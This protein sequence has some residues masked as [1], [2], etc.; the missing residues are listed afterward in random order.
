MFVRAL[1]EGTQ[2]NLATIARTPL[3]TRFYLAGGTAVALH[4]GHRLSYDLD[5]FSLQPFPPDLP[6]RALAPLGELSVTQESE[7]TFLGAFNGLQI[8][9]FIYPYS[10]LED[11]VVW[12]G[13][14]I[15][16][17]PDIATMKLDAISSRGKKRDFVDLYII[18]QRAFPLSQAIAF[19][20]Q[21]YA[22]VRYNKF[23]LLK[24]LVYFEDAEGDEPPQMLEACD[25]SAVKG[26]FEDK[27]RRLM[28]T[29]RR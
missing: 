28:W 27:V 25:W 26:F 14:Q 17:L 19:F 16:S 8:S 7:G 4:L 9:F 20:E 11:P 5:F 22:S 12:Q 15:A 18:C 2:S 1:P 23:H 21:R 24:S 3:A 6:R 29:L 10:L 13:I